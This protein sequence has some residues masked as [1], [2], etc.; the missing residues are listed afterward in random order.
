MNQPQVLETMA[1]YVGI[2][3]YSRHVKRKKRRETW[4][5]AVNRVITMHA[6]KYGDLV[7]FGERLEVANAIKS[8]Q[9]LPSMRSMQFADPELV[10]RG[11]DM[12]LYNCCFSYVDRPRFFGELMMNLL[13]G[14]GA[15]MN[16]EPRFTE[17]LPDIKKP[18]GEGEWVVSDSIEGWAYAVQAC[19][20]QYF[21]G[22]GYKFDFSQVRL[23]GAPLSSGVGRAPGPDG[24]RHAIEM[25][26]KV[27][28][29]ALNAGQ[30]KLRPIQVYDVAMYIADAVRS[31]GVR[32]SATIVLFDGNDQ[33]MLTAKADPSWMKEN[34]Q[35]GRSNN[36]AIM[37]RD[38]KAS[39]EKVCGILDGGKSWGEPGFIIVDDLDFGIN[40]CAEIGL[41]PLLDGVSG[42]QFCNLSSVNMA[43]CESPS[44]FYAACRLASRIG[45]WQAGY[46]SFKY[47]GEVSEKITEREALI[48]VSLTGMAEAGEWAFNESVLRRGAE[49][50]KEENARVAKSIGINPAA[51]CTAVKP[52]GTGTLACGSV[53]HG[54]HAAMSVKGIRNI[55]AEA[56][57][58]LAE[59][60]RETNS[61]AVSVSPYSDDRL[62][63]AFPFEISENALTVD[64]MPALTQLKRVLTVKKAWVDTGKRPEL[65]VDSRISN[66]VSNTINLHEDEWRKAFDFIW[67]NREHFTGVAMIGHTGDLDYPAAPYVAVYSGEELYEM[68]GK[69]AFE[70]GLYLFGHGD[71]AD[72]IEHDASKRTPAQEVAMRLNHLRGWEE[73]R[74]QWKRPDFSEVIEDTDEH[75]KV[76]E[77][78][79]CAGGACTM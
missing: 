19:V 48:G 9:V 38:D 6:T 27:F 8:R 59:H 72:F 25:I 65:C 49:I 50:V 47:L 78:V 29:G 34:P 76:N 13:C 71:D 51:R 4:D 67:E 39:F 30:E 20:D 28:D 74:Q 2:G 79:A 60:M 43:K 18:N 41:Y 75:V 61:H 17:K 3:K 54:V 58:P 55:E 44:E 66:N 52:E 36:S 11:Q 14:T 42:W 35:R 56:N 7:P 24:L 64:Q 68:Y 15:G 77:T 26:E 32:R 1:D 62:T 10:S 22:V 69:D 31:G 53:A 70:E 63:V 21:R 16:L 12:K 23:K 33:E 37:L 73:M 40:P 45:T 46:T 57:E 5:E